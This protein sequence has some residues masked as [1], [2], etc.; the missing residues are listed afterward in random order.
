MIIAQALVERGMLDSLVA[1]IAGVP[2]VLDAHLGTGHG[3]WVVV[4][5]VVAFLFWALTP[6]R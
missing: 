2:Q 4:G 6:R 3:K 5:L 1:A